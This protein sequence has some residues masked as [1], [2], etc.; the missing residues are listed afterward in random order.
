MWLPENKMGRVVQFMILDT[1]LIKIAYGVTHFCGK[2]RNV[3]NI[4]DE[5]KTRGGFVPTKHSR[6]CSDHFIS[7][8]YY[9]LSRMLLKTSVLPLFGFTEHLEENMKNKKLKKKMR[10]QQ[11]KINSLSDIIKYLKRKTIIDQNAVVKLNNNFSVFLWIWKRIRHI[12]RTRTEVQGIVDTVTNSRI[13][14]SP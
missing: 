10:L 13:L 6:I 11:K 4:V 9:P 3:T 14:L 2:I 1:N 12:I 7:L 5:S 8:D